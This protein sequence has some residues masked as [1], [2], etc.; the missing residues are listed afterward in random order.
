MVY[1]Q[2]DETITEEI[3]QKINGDNIIVD[4]FSRNDLTKIGNRLCKDLLK[5]KSNPRKVLLVNNTLENVLQKENVIRSEVFTGDL[6]DTF[7]RDLAKRIDE[8]MSKATK[9]TDLRE[10]CKRINEKSD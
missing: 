3:I 7:L 6:E 4:F 2:I 1:T 8:Q 9:S 5:V 10:I